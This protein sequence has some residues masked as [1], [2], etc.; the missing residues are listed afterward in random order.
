[1]S[2]ERRFDV[3][4]FKPKSEAE[5]A[6]TKLISILVIIWAVAVFGFQVLLIGAGKPV[7]EQTLID[8]RALWPAVQQAAPAESDLQEFSRVLLTTLGKNTTIKENDR[9]LMKQA[10]GVTVNLL[11]PSSDSAEGAAEA[12]GLGDSG[13]DPLLRDQLET[14]YIQSAAMGYGGVEALP[15][16]M[17]KYL[18]HK[19]SFFTDATF[20]GFPF[21]YFY[22]AQFLLILFIILCLV[23]ARAVDKKNTRLGIEE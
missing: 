18:I 23:Y 10:L 2:E 8:F 7:E 17:E 22:T 9:E 12:I 3:N 1:M 4:F 13:F 15:E 6:N 21:H 16:A 11:N 14:H 19:R 20:L 5:K